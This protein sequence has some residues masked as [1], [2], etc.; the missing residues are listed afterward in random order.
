[1]CYFRPVFLKRKSPRLRIGCLRVRDRFEAV[2]IPLNKTKKSQNA[3]NEFLI[4]DNAD[5]MLA[6]SY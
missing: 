2:E 1:L 4:E 3:R 5:D 6:Q